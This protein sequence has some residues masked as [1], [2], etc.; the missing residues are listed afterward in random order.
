MID[1][2]EHFNEIIAPDPNTKIGGL[3]LGDIEGAQDIQLLRSKGITH[4]LT[5]LGEDNKVKF[6]FKENEIDHKFIVALDGMDYPIRDHFD[7]TYA[8]ITAARQTGNVFV[9][10]FA[11]VTRS[12]TIVIAYLIK[13]TKKSAEECY[14]HVKSRRSYAFPNKGFFDQLIKYSSETQT[15]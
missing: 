7:E 3:Y 14:K 12:P 2:E 13:S 10:C 15:E 6:E 9:H 11:G 1:I 5:L 4:V 8:Y